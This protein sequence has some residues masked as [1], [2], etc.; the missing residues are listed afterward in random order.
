[1]YENFVNII[2]HS[3]QHE[4][5]YLEHLLLHLELYTLQYFMTIE[6]KCYFVKE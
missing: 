2:G 3:L 4:N 6:S 5:I 1:M